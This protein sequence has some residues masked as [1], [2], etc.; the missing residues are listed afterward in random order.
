MQGLIVAITLLAAVAYIGWRTYSALAR[1]H[2]PC[3]GCQGCALRDMARTALKCKTGLN[4]L[5]NK[6]CGLPK[7]P[8]LAARKA[9][10]AIC[11]ESTSYAMKRFF[12]T[13]HYTNGQRPQAKCIQKAPGDR[14]I[15][16]QLYHQSQCHRLQHPYYGTAGNDVTE[17]FSAY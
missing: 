6:P 3:H 8:V 13:N 15:Q 17:Q 5:P 4:V 7:R 14:S 10:L 1:A 9:C 16:K 2:D 11:C 12:A